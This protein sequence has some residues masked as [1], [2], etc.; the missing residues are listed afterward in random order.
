VWADIVI[1]I[2]ST[3]FGFMIIP[4]V[5]DSLNGKSFVNKYTALMTT[6]GLLSIGIAYLDLQ[7]WISAIST[8]FSCSMWIIISNLSWKNRRVK[9]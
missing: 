9:V 2:V 6:L 1:S 7:L 8:F 3:C 4:Q 5:I